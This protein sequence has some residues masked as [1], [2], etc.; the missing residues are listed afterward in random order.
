MFYKQ[1]TKSR[2]FFKKDDFSVAI[3]GSVNNVF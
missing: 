3:N 1:D 2:Y